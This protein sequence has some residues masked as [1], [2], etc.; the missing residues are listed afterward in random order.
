[1]QN[2]NRGNW[3]YFLITLVFSV[4]FGTLSK[5]MECVSGHSRK[6]VS[7]ENLVK[8]IPKGSTL[9]LGELHGVAEISVAQVDVLKQLRKRGHLVDVGL[10]FFSYAHQQEVDQYVRG[11]ISEAEFLSKI[12]WPKSMDF[13][14]YR[15]QA[16]FPS[17]DLGE[18]TMAINAPRSLT[19]AIA[20]RGLSGLSQ[21]EQSLLPPGLEL[22]R[23]D[24]FERFR[25]LMGGHV[26]EAD[27]QRYFEAQSVWDDTMAWQLARNE[28][29]NTKVVVVGEFHVQFG[30]GLPNRLDRRIPGANIKTLGFVNIAGLSPEEVQAIPLPHPKWGQREN[31]I[32]LVNISENQKSAIVKVLEGFGR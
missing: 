32:C 29:H 31:Y 2:A 15:G 5:A 11:K 10:E 23:A 21:A 4:G 17:F 28:T 30:G 20:K 22:G 12:E 25:D 3:S 8:E 7:L 26:G 16:L 27:L 14:H 13:S 19:G 6:P 1:M 9:I 18:T 24:Y